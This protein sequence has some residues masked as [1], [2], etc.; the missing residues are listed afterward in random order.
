MNRQIEFNKFGGLY[1]YQDT[2]DFLQRAYSEVIQYQS[3]GLGDKWVISG[4]VESGSTVS[5]GSIVVGSEIINFVG[6][7][8]QAFVTIEQIKTQEQFNDTTLKDTYVIRRAKMVAIPDANSFAY[9]GLKRLPLAGSTIYDS[10]DKY[11]QILKS[12]INFEPEV[13]LNGLVVTNVIT[14]P[15]TCNISGGLVMFNGQLKT[16]PAYAGTYPVY[17]TEAGAYQN[18]IPGSGLYIT[19]DPYTSQRYT[20]VLN[21][22]MVKSGKIEIYETL[23]DRFVNGVGRWE[24]KGFSLCAALQG[25]VPVGL[26][27]DGVAVADVTDAYYATAGPTRKKGTN[28]TTLTPDQQG[29]YEFKAVSDD[30]DSQSPTGSGV[31][32]S[33]T[34]FSVNSQ[35]VEGGA[36]SGTFGATVTVK[37]QN[38]AQLHSNL[39]PVNVVV[40]VKRN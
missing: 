10:L 12:L 5:D 35:N 18:T 19:F 23:S 8:I 11:H 9:A 15:Q 20:D 27:F 37:P 6:G 25:R 38:D 39:Q 24:M 7:P 2:L 13:I 3:R 21:R 36:S 16:A 28:T 26:W 31:L 22:A 32:R 4:C 14:G 1:V 29:S 17:L 40:Y 33:V 34:R 30:G